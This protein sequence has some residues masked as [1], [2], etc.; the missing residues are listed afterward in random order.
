MSDDRKQGIG[1]SDASPKRDEIAEYYESVRR[2]QEAAFKV[3]EE[4]KA[5]GADGAELNRLWNRYIDAGYTGD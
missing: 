3:W 4:A 1:G 5:R 2:R